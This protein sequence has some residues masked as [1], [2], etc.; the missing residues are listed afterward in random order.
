MGLGLSMAV[1]IDATIIRIMLVPSILK[2]LDKASWWVPEGL[3]SKIKTVKLE[4]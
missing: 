3:K 2:I 4:H 1:L